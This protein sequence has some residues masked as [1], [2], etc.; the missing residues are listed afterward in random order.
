M[1]NIVTLLLPMLSILGCLLNFDLSDNGSID[2]T[3]DAASYQMFLFAICFSTGNYLMQVGDDKQSK[4]KRILTNAGVR[5]SSYWLGKYVADYVNWFVLTITA[6]LT[7]K[8]AGYSRIQGNFFDFYN[9]I[10]NF[11]MSYISFC[12]LFSIFYQDGR[13]AAKRASFWILAIGYQSVHNSDELFFG[14][15]N[16]I[17]TLYEALAH[18]Y[19]RKTD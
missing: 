7:L 2:F 5:S 12:N 1:H 6:C 14:R 8:Y 4:A 9:V 15:F 19:H 18:F 13:D 17:Y 16:P 10:F 3:K 11:G